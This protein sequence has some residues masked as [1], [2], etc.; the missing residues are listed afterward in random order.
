MSCLPLDPLPAVR[1]HNLSFPTHF[2]G[3]AFQGVLSLSCDFFTLDCSCT[4][5][6]A[7]HQC[8]NSVVPK[9][10]EFCCSC[11]GPISS[12]SEARLISSTFKAILSKSYIYSLI[13]L[14]HLDL[15]LISWNSFLLINQVQSSVLWQETWRWWQN[16]SWWGWDSPPSTSASWQNHTEKE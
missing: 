14:K 16:E 10:Q 1:T 15:I 7:P 11:D 13:V 9:N 5:R 6:H 3:S 8:I 2:N 4:A 12:R